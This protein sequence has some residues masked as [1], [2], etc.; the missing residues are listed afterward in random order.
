MSWTM[1]DP[2]SQVGASYGA[3]A[4]LGDQ[5]ADVLTARQWR[6]LRPVFGSRSG[7]PFDV[8]P[9]LAGEVAKLLHAAAA[10]GRMSPAVAL[11]ALGLSESAGRAASAGRPWRW[12]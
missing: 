9:S 2:H 1:T 5:L 11:L 6:K 4:T 3:V 7:D 12:S 8:P 10:S